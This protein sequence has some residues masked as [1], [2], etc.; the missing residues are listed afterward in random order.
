MVGKVFAEDKDTKVN[1]YLKSLRKI[2]LQMQKVE[3]YTDIRI[4][5]QRDAYTNSQTEIHIS[6]DKQTE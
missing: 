1:F 2:T 3:R 6:I 5:R 4:D